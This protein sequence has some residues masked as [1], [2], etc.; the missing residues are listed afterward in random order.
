M[1]T[2]LPTSPDGCFYTTS[3]NASY[4]NLSKP[5]RCM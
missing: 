5:Q 2:E 1:T 3:R 4:V